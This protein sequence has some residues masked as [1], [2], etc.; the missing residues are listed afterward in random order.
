MTQAGERRVSTLTLEPEEL[1]P[2]S[3]AEIRAEI[4]RCLPDLG[5]G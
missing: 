1:M 5:N 3:Q 4:D 2:L